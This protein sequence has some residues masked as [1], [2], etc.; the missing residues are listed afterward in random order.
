MH[1][2]GS[3]EKL[4]SVHFAVSCT[5]DAQRKFDRAVAILHSFWYEEAQKAFLGV[6]DADPT[7]AMA[8]WG[9]AMSYY[10]QL[11]EP[12]NAEAL[13]KGWQAAETG[14]KLGPKTQRERDY[15]SAID[16]FYKSY[17][18]V[19]HE[20]RALLYTTAMQQLQE[21]YPMDSEAA[22]F[23]ALALDSTASPSDKTYANYRKADAILEPLFAKQPNHPGIAHYII[24][25]DDVPPLAAQALPAAR[26]YA[27]IAPSVPHALHM[28]SHIF[29]RLGLWDESIQSNL[30]SWGA[31]QDYAAKN[32]PGAAF[33]NGLHAL[34][35]LE[36]AYLQ[37]GE[38]AKAKGVVDLVA[39]VARS[40]P[41]DLASSYAFTA[42]PARFSIELGRWSDAEALRVH[43]L[44]YP[45]TLF[46]WTP[47]TIEFANA[48]GAARLGDVATAR[49]YLTKLAAIRDSLLAAKQTYW[50][51]EVE[52]ER[53]EA[54]GWIAHAQKNEDEALAML[55]S[56]A[57]LE[58]AT[59]KSNVTPG[60]LVPA[61]EFVGDLLLELGRGPEAL[62]EYEAALT[63][64]P[65]RFHGLYGAAKAARLAGDATKA[66]LYYG[67][68][69]AIA[70]H[71][72]PGVP[73]IAEA[74]AYL[75][76]S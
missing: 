38:F 66:R 46:P 75:A 34:D 36:Y 53:L 15:V 59:E 3:P 63:T 27:S 14:R 65:N 32:F 51:G 22:V 55:H 74:E 49:G 17:D 26:K 29:T 2:G 62:L 76:S 56:A 28:P 25:S 45:W 44:D 19:D 71:A 23:Y 6:A 57:A 60:P 30:A 52:I 64:S 37:S 13:L 54:A 20:T 42:I 50:S 72:D 9:V 58:D 68:L 18:K 12:P 40:Q 16:L 48:L 35:Y 24:H 41:Q 61:H 10:H 43:P 73:A 7:C 33:S 31:A 69:L 67:K 5:P 70:K 1:G 47:A 21:R 11:W 39:A 4:G 8:Y